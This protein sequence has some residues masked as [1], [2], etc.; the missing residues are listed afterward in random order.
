[1]HEEAGWNCANKNRN[2]TTAYIGHCGSAGGAH[3]TN[4]FF[5]SRT[6]ADERT[7]AQTMLVKSHDCAELCLARLPDTSL[8]LSAVGL[9]ACAN[10]TGGVDWVRKAHL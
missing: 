8:Y 5:L 10:A 7:L 2:L 3:P 4:F 1:M 6:P 9:A